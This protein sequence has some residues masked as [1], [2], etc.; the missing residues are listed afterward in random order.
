VVIAT[1]NLDKEKRMATEGAPM[2]AGTGTS[3]SI[4]VTKSQST[5][6]P[7]SSSGPQGALTNILRTFQHQGQQ[8]YLR[9][10]VLSVTCGQDLAQ[11]IY[12]AACM[13]S[14]RCGWEYFWMY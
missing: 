6:I 1:T 3:A 12:R 10:I 2:S 9:S 13:S 8:Y 5:S 7:M 14:Y 11:R 4:V